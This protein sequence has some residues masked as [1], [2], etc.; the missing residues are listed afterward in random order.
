MVRNS[1]IV[2]GQGLDYWEGNEH[3]NNFDELQQAHEDGQNF[4][5]KTENLRMS[6]GRKTRD[7]DNL[8]DHLEDTEAQLYDAEV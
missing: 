5:R 3:T 1:N 6:D 2:K 7:Q 4:R 8:L